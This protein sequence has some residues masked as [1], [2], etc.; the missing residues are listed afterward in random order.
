M[1]WKGEGDRNEV[2]TCE[3]EQS[4]LVETMHDNVPDKLAVVPA[5]WAEKRLE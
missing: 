1:V 3:Y 2:E 5:E 4:V